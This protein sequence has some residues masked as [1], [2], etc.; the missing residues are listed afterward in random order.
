MAVLCGKRGGLIINLTRMLHFGKKLPE[1]LRRK[2]DACC[3]IDLAFNGATRVGRAAN[4]IFADGVKEYEKQG[5]G[6]EWKL[7][8]QGGP[9]GYYGRCYRATP[10]EGRHVQDNQAF[11]WNPSITGTKSEDTILVTRDGF[12]FLSSPTSAWP[13]LKVKFGNKTYRRADIKLE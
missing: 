9:T 6:E 5:F 11:A 3:A 7:H 1:D 8:H 4:D 13:G 2:H 10:T 12:E